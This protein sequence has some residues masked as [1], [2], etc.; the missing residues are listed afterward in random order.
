MKNEI[1][2][3]Q[4]VTEFSSWEIHFSLLWMYTRVYLLIVQRIFSGRNRLKCKACKKKKRNT[5]GGRSYKKFKS[6][7][8]HIIKYEFIGWV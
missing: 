5:F 2:D 3:I 8:C 7:K 1:F 6:D 4:I